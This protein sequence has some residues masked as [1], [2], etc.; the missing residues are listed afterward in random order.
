VSGYPDEPACW[1]W[2]LPTV[3]TQ[4]DEVERLLEENLRLVARLG[5]DHFLPEGSCRMITRD[6]PNY[7]LGSWH[8]ERCAICGIQPGHLVVDHDHRTGL[9]R[10][11]LCRGCNVSE[12]L[13]RGDGTVYALYRERPPAVILGVR[14]Y[15][16]GRGWED[17]WWRDV[18][19]ARQ[20][21][22]NRDWAP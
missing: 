13:N 4:E 5:M 20:L 11:R 15:Y 22:G 2:P 19:L 8:D 17:G 9:V 6:W 7:L 16:V 14:N 12:G 21:T 10:G 1:S 18:G 3:L